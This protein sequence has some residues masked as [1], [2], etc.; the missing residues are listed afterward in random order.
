MSKE[1][2]CCPPNS[3]PKLDYHGVIK[4]K[5][6][7][8]SGVK[9]YITGDNPKTIIFCPDVF[10]IESG[11]TRQAA[12]HLSEFGYSVVVTDPFNGNPWSEKKGFGKD[13]SEWI[14]KIEPKALENYVLTD[15]LPH[16]K[17]HG[18]T[19]F[20]MLGTC[21]GCWMGIR[22]CAVSKEI[23]VGVNWH[24]S[25]QIEEMHKGSSKDLMHLITQPQLLIPAQNDPDSVKEHGEFIKILEKTTHGKVEVHPMETQPHGFTVRGDLSDPVVKKAYEETLDYTRVFLEK[26]FK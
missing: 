23:K 26:Y 6:E 24:P 9:N 20:A 13:F 10:G 17:K 5:I 3:L 8:I 11:R 2:P 18:K 14:A 15:L 12:D 16:L 25:F 22:L 21:F 19:Q 7:E 4:G 1:H